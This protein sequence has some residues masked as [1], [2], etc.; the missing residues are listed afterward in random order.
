[1][2]FVQSF[3]LFYKFSTIL[4]N[5]SYLPPLSWLSDT[6]PISVSTILFPSSP[7]RIVVKLPSA[8]RPSPSLKPIATAAAKRP[9]LPIPRSLFEAGV[10][11]SGVVFLD[12]GQAYRI[13]RGSLRRPVRQQQ[14]KQHMY[15]SAPTS[16]PVANAVAS[17]S[18]KQT[19]VRAVAAESPAAI[20]RLRARVRQQHQQQHGF[21]C[22]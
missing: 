11:A 3:G 13:T 12:V 1:M 18:A 2:V 6:L 16:H 4:L 8:Y 7:P 5:E 17:T 9:L 14:Q 15:P 21:R 19:S 22:C 10:R 20:A